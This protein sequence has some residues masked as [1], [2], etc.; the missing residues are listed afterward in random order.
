MDPSLNSASGQPGAALTS[1]AP[2]RRSPS[3][4]WIQPLVVDVWLS[5]PGRDQ[6]AQASF[7]VRAPCARAS[8]VALIVRNQAHVGEPDLGLVALV[9][10]IKSDLRSLPLALVFNKVDIG[11]R[12]KPND[13]LALT[14][15][16]DPVLAIG[17]VPVSVL[18]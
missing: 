7:H 1:G 6:A 5:F 3:I 12:H 9:S 13:C 10:D 18:E 8:P 14:S 11:F 4:V 2:C 16:R 15:F 17:Q